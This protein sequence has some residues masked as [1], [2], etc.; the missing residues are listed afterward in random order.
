MQVRDIPNPKNSR[1]AMAS[2]Y[3]HKWRAAD[4]VE[5][6]QMFDKGVLEPVDRAD[7]PRQYKPIPGMMVRVVKPNRDGT[8]RKFKSRFVAK[9][10][11]QRFG[12]DYTETFAPVA[13]IATIKLVLAVAAHFRMVCFQFDVE[14]AFLLPDIDHVVYITDEQGNHYLCHKTLYGLKQSPHMWNRDLDAELKYHGM[15]QSKS[16]P[17]LYTRKT[18]EGWMIMASWVDDCV[19]ACTSPNMRDEF[20]EEFRYPFSSTSN[21][22]YCLKIKVDYT[23]DADKRILAP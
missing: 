18:D 15:V 22:D 4:R 19:G 14:G 10:F 5:M 21:L 2:P 16:D 1:E 12:I 6:D 20:F 9:G 7:I 23:V 13:A 8:V 11:W 3:A 17:C